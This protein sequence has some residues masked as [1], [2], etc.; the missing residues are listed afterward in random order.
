MGEGAVKELIGAQF[1]KLSHSMTPRLCRMKKDLSVSRRRGLARAPC[2]HSLGEAGGGLTSRTRSPPTIYR[3]THQ[4]SDDHILLT[5]IWVFNHV[6]YMS[7]Q[8]CQICSS[9]SKNKALTT[10]SKATKCSRRPDRA[11]CTYIHLVCGASP[12]AR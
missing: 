9:P 8:F 7:C 6:A 1:S 4:V 11:P 2:K 12:A 3:V 5:L 10:K